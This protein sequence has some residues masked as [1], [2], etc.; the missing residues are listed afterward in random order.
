M[1]PRISFLPTKV[2]G[3]VCGR[4]QSDSLAC[5]FGVVSSNPIGKEFRSTTECCLEVPLCFEAWPYYWGTFQ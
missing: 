3:D 1:I 2:A 5:V 4:N